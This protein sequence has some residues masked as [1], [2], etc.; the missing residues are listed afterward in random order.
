M[1]VNAI[2]L[3][4]PLTNEMVPAATVA[5]T[6]HGTSDGHCLGIGGITLARPKE[7]SVVAMQHVCTGLGLEGLVQPESTQASHSQHRPIFAG[8]VEG[9]EYFGGHRHGGDAGFISSH[10]CLSHQATVVRNLEVSREVRRGDIPG[11]GV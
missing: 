10:T 8:R 6:A 11:A 2:P 5:Y 4:T 1:P 9:E 7:G 3:L